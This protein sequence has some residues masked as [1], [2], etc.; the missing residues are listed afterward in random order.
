MENDFPEV[1]SCNRVFS[2]N[3]EIITQVG[4]KQFRERYV[5][6]ADSNFFEFFD[7]PRI[8][9]DKSLVTLPLQVLPGFPIIFHFRLK[10]I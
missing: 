9:G 8:E 5:V 4:E 1:E 3:N 6:L 2:G 7:F 10:P